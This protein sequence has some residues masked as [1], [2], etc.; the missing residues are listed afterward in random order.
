MIDRRDTVEVR[1]VGLMP[2]EF[3]GAVEVLM[4]R[5]PVWRRGYGPRERRA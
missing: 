5:I 1:L 2:D 4:A 3:A